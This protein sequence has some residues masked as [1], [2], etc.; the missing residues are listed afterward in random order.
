M[1]LLAEVQVSIGV[2]L[3]GPTSVAIIEMVCEVV[4]IPIV[5]TVT[6]I[7]I[8]IEEKLRA[9]VSLIYISAETVRFFRK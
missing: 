7:D 8:L 3:N 9:G 1:S 2:V 5:S 4:D 6:S